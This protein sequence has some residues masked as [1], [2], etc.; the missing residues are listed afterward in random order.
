[1]FSAIAAFSLAS[2]RLKPEIGGVRIRS[3]VFMRVM[4]RNR[5]GG[6]IGGCG[7]DPGRWR[8]GSFQCLF[9]CTDGLHPMPCE[10][11][12]TLES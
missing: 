4:G 8:Q 9:R 2:E 6:K 10:P 12:R 11:S 7:D 3:D 5:A 1:M